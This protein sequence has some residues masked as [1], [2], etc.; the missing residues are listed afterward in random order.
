MAYKVV[1]TRR[2]RRALEQI[3]RYLVQELKEP[4]AAERL[5]DEI[6]RCYAQLAQ[7]PRMFQKCLAPSLSAQGCRRAVVGKYIVLYKVD[8]GKKE[9][10][11]LFIVHG[12]REYERLL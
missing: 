3:I 2:A 7:M 10:R 6:Q 5:L 4:Q 11:V 1:E 8:E 9:V 12:S